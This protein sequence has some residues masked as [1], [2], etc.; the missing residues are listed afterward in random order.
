VIQ[1]N[2]LAEETNM[3]IGI[4]ND[5]HKFWAGDFG[6]QYVGRNQGAEWV[7]SNTRLFARILDRSLPVDS[8]LEFGA[9]IGLNLQALKNI[10]PGA[11]LSGVE[12]NKNAFDELSNID[13]VTG[14]HSSIEGFEPKQQFDLVFT[15]TVL[16][17]INPDS[18][19]IVYD[20]LYSCSKRYILIAE[21]YN[22][23]PVE[24]LYRG[25][26]A[27]LFKRDFAGEI[28]QRH[29]DLR[30]LD[31]GFVYHGDKFLQDDITWFLMEKS[32]R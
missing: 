4:D 21:Y 20:K 24:I 10:L 23:T 27:K 31:Y 26:S 7:A 12:I 5:Q 32:G 8:V 11:T 18:L 3:N 1:I 15:K 13:G 2:L 16:I 29:S 6:D 25:H 14:H 9:N 28:M 19:N 17:H 30:L 22:Q